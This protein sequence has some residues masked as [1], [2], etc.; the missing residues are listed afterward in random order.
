MMVSLRACVLLGICVSLV[1]ASPAEDLRKLFDDHHAWEKQEWPAVAQ[2]HGDYS[3]ADQLHDVSLAGYERRHQARLDMQARLHAIPR[4]ELSPADQLNYDLFDWELARDIDGYRFGGHLV[5]VGG[6]MGPQTQLPELH[7]RVNF[8]TERDYRNYLSR[9]RQVPGMIADTRALLEKGLAE[10]RTPPEITLVNVASQFDKLSSGGL[11]ALAEPFDRFPD[12]IPAATRTEIRAEFDSLIPPIVAAC[13]TLRGYLADTYIPGSRKTIAA[14]DWPDGQA[15]Y[16]HQLRVM[17]TTDLSARQ[18]HELGLSEVKRIRAEMMQVIARSDYLTRFPDQKNLDDDTL[19]RNF[20]RYLREDPRFYYDR[21]EDLLAG[22]REICKRIDPWLPTLFGHLPRLPY[23]VKEIPAVT[24]PTQ[25]TAYYQPGSLPNGQPGWFYANTYALKQRPK[26]EMIA[27]AVHEAVPGHHLQIAI[28]QELEDVPAF[29]K[30]FWITAYGEGWA[31]YSERL[32]IEM[33]LYSDPYDDFGRL[34]Y[35]MWRATRL[36]VDPGMHA[37]GWSRQ[38]AIDFM[39][40]NTAL[41]EINI[42]N[43][44]DRYIS[45]PGQACGYKIGELKIRELRTLAEQQLG[46]DFDL[47]SFHD[48]VLGTGPI[49]M[50]VLE[51]R[52][53]DWINTQQRTEAN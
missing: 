19:F 40:A 17:T 50:N 20:T 12:T 32:G 7:A 21:P 48:Q 34:L 27:L 46:A 18:I 51:Q 35:E 47:R 43:E 22:Y 52:I 38:Q 24:A 10:G 49:P 9:L 36:V 2:A 29:R 42:R 8:R 15:Y 26:Y 45:W 53:R 30:S 28:A 25:T 1:Q 41:S 23:G 16:A 13:Q 4:A 5:A 33:G 11:D 39:L 6:R 14:H 3:N 31:L 44:V 37:L